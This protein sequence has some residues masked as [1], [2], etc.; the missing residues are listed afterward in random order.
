LIFKV[1]SSY[2]AIIRLRGLSFCAARKN[3]LPSGGISWVVVDESTMIFRFVTRSTIHLDHESILSRSSVSVDCCFSIQPQ[4]NL[5]EAVCCCEYEV[6]RIMEHGRASARGQSHTT[7]L[8]D[9]RTVIDPWKVPRLASSK[10]TLRYLN[11][12]R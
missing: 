9:S 5:F 7:V 11:C 12:L 3:L 8:L 1:K 2:L 6:R 10:H 4:P